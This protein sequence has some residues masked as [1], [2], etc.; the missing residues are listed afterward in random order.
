L[1]SAEMLKAAA[2]RMRGVRANKKSV[3]ANEKRKG[4]DVG[5]VWRLTTA[6]AMAA[7][8]VCGL[9]AT[10]AS[11]AGVRVLTVG[12]PGAGG[13]PAKVGNILASGLDSGSSLTMTTTAGGNI[14]LTCTTS[15][16][17]GP[18]QENPVA[19]GSSRLLLKTW[20]IEKCTSNLPMTASVT[21]VKVTGTPVN[22]TVSDATGLPIVIGPDADL[23][24][25]ATLKLANKTEAVCTY[26][27]VNGTVNGSVTPDTSQWAFTSQKFTVAGPAA[28]CGGNGF[29]SAAYNPVVDES[30]GKGPV[31]VN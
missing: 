10:S 20:M 26:T 29:L 11:A 18:L 16:I 14:G 19:P 8:T 22:M 7:L 2:N 17:K 13:T 24:I 5:L 25:T 4:I 9:A 3:P 27:P 31:F 15:T 30:L 1:I 28:V 21:G 12:K 23:K 6:A